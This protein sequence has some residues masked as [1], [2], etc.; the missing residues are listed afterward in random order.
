MSDHTLAQPEPATPAGPRVV[1]RDRRLVVTL[2]E[3]Y[4]D[5]HAGKPFLDRL[6]GATDLK[7]ML[8][9]LGY[10]V[11]REALYP[12]PTQHAH[13]VL[14]TLFIPAKPIDQPEGQKDVPVRLCANRTCWL[15]IKNLVVTP[16]N[17]TAAE[18]VIVRFALQCGPS[19]SV[20]DFCEVVGQGSENPGQFT[21]PQ[22]LLV[23]PTGCLRIDLF[24]RD[25][26]SEAMLGIEADQWLVPDV[27]ENRALEARREALRRRSP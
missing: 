6:R 18:S 12:D 1:T 4:R 26:Y 17:L 23:P 20:I 22:A 19:M 24:N 16:L 7:S 15:Y 9:A 14:K 21:P 11:P 13:K 5:T 3:F 27:A 8:E 2:S 10:A 25:Q